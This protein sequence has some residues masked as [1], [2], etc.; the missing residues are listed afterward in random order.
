M[1]AAIQ[2]KPMKITLGITELQNNNLSQLFHGYLYVIA[3]QNSSNSNRRGKER[4]EADTNICCLNQL[5]TFFSQHYLMFDYIINVA[6]KFFWYTVFLHMFQT[7][8]TPFYCLRS[9]LTTSPRVPSLPKY[10]NTTTTTT[11]DLNK[12]AHG[13][14]Y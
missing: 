9:Q 8:V 1:R 7:S 13:S 6:G 2:L 4:Q 12:E 14:T 5:F 10:C 3:T 11:S